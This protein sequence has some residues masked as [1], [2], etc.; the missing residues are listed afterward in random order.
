MGKSYRYSVCALLFF[1]TT[2]NYFDRQV[3]GILKPLLEHQFA[4]SE[5]DYSYFVIIFQA[6][7]AF[8]LL[9]VGAI[10]DRIGTKAGY[11]LCILVWNLAS[12]AHAFASSFG[13]FALARGVLGFAESGNF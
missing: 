8:G 4:W 2:I 10:I 12:I 11:A 5:S 13:S 6:S 1:A 9:S 7:Y 3:L